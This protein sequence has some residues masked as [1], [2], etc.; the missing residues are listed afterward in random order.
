MAR[1]LG[2]QHRQEYRLESPVVAHELLANGREAQRAQHRCTQRSISRAASEAAVRPPAHW[3]ALRH[4]HPIPERGPAAST[5]QL[6]GAGPSQQHPLHQPAPL[7]SSA[8]SSQAHPPEAFSSAPSRKGE[9][10]AARTASDARCIRACTA[11]IWCAT[12]AGRLASPRPSTAVPGQVS[13]C[14]S[15][16]LQSRQRRQQQGSNRGGG[17]VS[18]STRRLIA[19][20]CSRQPAVAGPGTGS[21]L[22]TSL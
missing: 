6:P 3:Q 1:A 13:S 19:G 14:C 7:S 2:R 12:A 18:S 11:P 9:S 21:Q 15:G 8:A 20:V 22:H 16:G 5:Q 4:A 17:W 10:Q